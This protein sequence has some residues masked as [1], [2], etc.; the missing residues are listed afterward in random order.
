MSEKSPDIASGHT[1]DTAIQHDLHQA[2]DEALPRR[3]A[4]VF[5]DFGPL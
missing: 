3:F 1:T 4:L 5:W 2:G